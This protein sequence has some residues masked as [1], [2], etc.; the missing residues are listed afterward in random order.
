MIYLDYAANTPVDKRVLAKFETITL[1]YYGNANSLHDNGIQAKRLID[2]ASK[3]ISSYFNC[4]PSC[5]IY[6]SGSSEANNFIIKGLAAQH[7]KNKAHIIIASNSHS[8]VIAPCNYLTTLGYE[9]DVIPLNKKGVVDLEKLE[10]TIQD[11]TILVSIT[12]VDGEIG[13]IQPISDI[14]KLLKKY[15]NV[16]FHVDAT[17]AIGKINIDYSGVDFLTFAPHKFYGLNGIGAAINFNNTKLTPLIHGGKSTTVYRSGT[18]TTAS[19]V[20]FAY[21]L[22]IALKNQEKRYNHVLLLNKYLISE[23]KKIPNITI[24]MPANPVANIINFSVKNA[25]IVVKKLYKKGIYVSRKSACSSTS[26]PSTS[27]LAITN[28]ISRATNSIRVSLSYLTT[29]EEIKKFIKILRSCC[30][31]NN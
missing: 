3:E 4:D 18:P 23:L 5:I 16:L 17:Q 25:K 14:S 28:D 27:V 12:A 19:I 2:K 7:I 20:A 24:N 29:K 26:S 30:N 21:S 11:N 13:A 6:T 1:S 22:K 15:K 8:S 31:E 10:N 9:V